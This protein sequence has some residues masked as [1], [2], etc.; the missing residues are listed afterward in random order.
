MSSLFL[1]EVRSPTGSMRPS[2]LYVIAMEGMGTGLRGYQ[3]PTSVFP[4][5]CAIT[6]NDEIHRE[7]NRSPSLVAVLTVNFFQPSFFLLRPARPVSLLPSRPF[8]RSFVYYM[9]NYDDLRRCMQN[10]ASLTARPRTH[11][12][13]RRRAD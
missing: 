8:P 1:A 3:V 11:A 13:K 6:H 5:R 2:L 7:E 12:N 9:L 10:T 4:P